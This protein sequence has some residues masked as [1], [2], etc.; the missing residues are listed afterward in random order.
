MEGRTIRYFD[1]D[2]YKHGMAWLA[3]LPLIEAPEALQR[4]PV[5]H[6]V[7][8]KPHY[9][10]VIA[11]RLKAMNIGKTQLWNVASLREEGK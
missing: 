10:K 3:G 1:G 4:D 6:L 7:I 2:V 8:F 11:E 5:D 9:F